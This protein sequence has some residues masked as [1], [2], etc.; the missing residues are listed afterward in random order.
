MKRRGKDRSGVNLDFLLCFAFTRTVISVGVISLLCPVLLLGLLT[1]WGSERE[2]NGAP[3]LGS[4]FPTWALGS[5][6]QD[7]GCD[8]C[9]DT[10]AGGEAERSYTKGKLS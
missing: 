9:T 6:S 5:E 4:P 10:A 3:F 8:T 1:P 7:W 2:G